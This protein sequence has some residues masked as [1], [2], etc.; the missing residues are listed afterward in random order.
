MSFGDLSLRAI[1][2]ESFCLS[3]SL[4]ILPRR[5]SELDVSPLLTQPEH[6]EVKLLEL[7][8]GVGL[9]GR[10]DG[11]LG[12]FSII[13]KLLFSKLS[14]LSRIG[15]QGNET[16]LLGTIILFCATGT[17]AHLSLLRFGNGA[18]TVEVSDGEIPLL[19]AT[20]GA[21]STGDLMGSTLRIILLLL[22]ST[23]RTLVVITDVGRFDR[24]GGAVVVVVVVS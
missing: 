16:A 3:C 22:F 5:C 23:S 8:L 18:P 20:G 1:I 4:D 19:V 17:L 6:S 12:G 11:G 2:F 21:G 7:E 10:D 14:L 15:M 9:L 13:G 24:G